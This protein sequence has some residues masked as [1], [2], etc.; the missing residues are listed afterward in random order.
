MIRFIAAGLLAA[1]CIAAPGTTSAKDRCLDGR[2]PTGQCVNPNLAESQRQ[3]AVIH[4]Q[5]KIS[6]THYPVVPGL[7]WIFRYSD[8]VRH[9]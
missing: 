4:S 2:T 6:R 5:P 3:S 8:P 7:D 1:T 9:K